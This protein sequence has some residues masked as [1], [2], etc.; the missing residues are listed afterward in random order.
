[1][2]AGPGGVMAREAADTG[3]RDGTQPDVS[4]V[5]RQ[6]FGAFVAYLAVTLALF[7]PMILPHLAD[8]KLAAV[9]WDGS[10]FV[11][12]LHWWPWALTHG[13][14]PLYTS[15]VWSPLGINLTWTTIAPVPGVLLAPLTTSLGPVET[16][17]IA[18]LLAPPLS[19][20]TAYLLCRRV[21]GVFAPSVAGGFV[22]GF[23]SYVMAQFAAGHIDLS[24]AF[25]IPV[26]GYL[27]VRRY[28]GSLRPV[29]FVVL[30]T[31]VLSLQFG[32]FTEVYATA[33]LFGAVVGG[34]ALAILPPAR[35][36]RVLSTA[37][38]TAAAY[39]L[40]AVV[41]SPFLYVA[42]AFPQPYRSLFT[43]PGSA[44]STLSYASDLLRFV[45][46]GPTAPF[47]RWP[48]AGTEIERFLTFERFGWYVPIT[49]VAIL[50]HLWITQ[51][52]RP[53]TKVLLLSFAVALVLAIGPWLWIGPVRVPM[54]WWL[55]QAIPVIR[56]AVPGRMMMYAFLVASVCVAIW[57]AAAPRSIWRWC[58][59]GLT[60]LL[61]IPNITADVW[62][63]DVR[64]PP[65]FST[66]LY[67]SY[68][69]QGSTVWIVDVDRGQ[70]MLWQAEANTAF[71]LAGAYLGITPSDVADVRYLALANGRLDEGNI[72]A[73][74][75][76]VADYGVATVVVGDEPA[77]VI[78]RLT[79]LLGVRPQ[80]VGGVT[81][82]RISRAR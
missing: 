23:S 30:M 52:G 50:V 70:Q 35:R 33:A 71:K 39:G 26:C 80:R 28:E 62:V 40:S 49:L 59:A 29:P 55:V 19:A 45:V 21:T 72:E 64:I 24:W 37:G 25:L 53:R 27:I 42:F 7:G 68:L 57:L 79:T 10:F 6:H 47:G 61:L 60:M 54:P 17:N 2:G 78:P 73:A 8:R 43:D 1:M 76:F 15:Q 74:P 75:S 18:A 82:F 20:W 12:A 16:F 4:K 66:G 14:D 56:R 67:R 31:T 48:S 46:P 81:I 51:H 38:W 11:W 22:F 3:A 63:S 36:H 9:P 77:W 44:R 65:F 32:I 13:A 5:R 41:V 58:A 34:L 69:S